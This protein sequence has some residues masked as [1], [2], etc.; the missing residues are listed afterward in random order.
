MPF[1][2]QFSKSDSLVSSFT[3]YFLLVLWCSSWCLVFLAYSM[4]DAPAAKAPMFPV[5]ALV[6]TVIA[7]PLVA[8]MLAVSGFLK[9]RVSTLGVDLGTTYSVVAFKDPNTKRITVVPADGL[10]TRTTAIVP[11]DDERI[12]TRPLLTPSVV[13]FLDDGSVLAGQGALSYLHTSPRNTV[14]NAKRLIGRSLAEVRADATLAAMPHRFGLLSSD[15]NVEDGRRMEQLAGFVITTEG[16]RKERVVSPV[17]VAVH[18]VTS[19]K[20][21][22]D[23]FLGYNIARKVVI[24]APAEFNT[25][26]RVQ[27]ANAFKR[28]GFKVVAMLNEPTAAA[29]AYG[30]DKKKDVDYILVYDFGGGTLDVSLLFVNKESV[31]VI[32]SSTTLVCRLFSLC[33]CKH[34]LCAFIRFGV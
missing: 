14:Y 26:Q 5:G 10:P 31:Q 24:A 32:V 1:R 16:G 12:D 7:V 15:A 28:A 11:G 29:L 22:V 19:M 20:V 6:F 23:K 13:A 25:S 30:L 18:V 33:C 8:T 4:P 34:R 21:A 17:D 3:S 27:T 9:M 2:F